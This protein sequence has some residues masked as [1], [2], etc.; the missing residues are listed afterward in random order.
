MTNFTSLE[1]TPKLL[2]VAT[3]NPG[4]VLEM[5]EYM[6]DLELQ[7]QLKPKDLEVEE[8]GKTFLAN[9]CLKASEVAKAT[10]KWAIADDSGLVVNAL[11]GRPGIY[12]ARYAPT[13]AEQI[14]RV[15]RELGDNPERLAQF[16]CA[17]AIARPDGTIA[18]KTEG[19]CHGEILYSPRGNG[20]FGYDP[21]FY[22]P[23]QKKTFA[24]ISPETKRSLSHRGQAF[25]ILLPQIKAIFT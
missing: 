13:V 18:L 21:I 8:T 15:L 5:Q 25:Q 3:G 10:K 7:L 14:E 22:L 17:L 11:D 24:E 12:S 2:V 9:A 19:I 20:G 6:A 16:V 1:T 23:S 4:K